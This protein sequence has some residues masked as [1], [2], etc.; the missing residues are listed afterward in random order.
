M[1]KKKTPSRVSA[2][3]Q[4]ALKKRM[5]I[6]YAT[7]TFVVLA[8]ILL[9]V[10]FYKGGQKDLS[11]EGYEK[12]IARQLGL[13]FDKEGELAFLSENGDTLAAI[14]IEIA[15]DNAERRIGLMFR[16]SMKENQGMLFIFPDEA[17]RSFWMR[18]TYMS[19]DMIFVNRNDEIVTIQ[20][21]TVPLTENSYFSTRPAVYVIEV[22]AGFA[23]RHGIKVGGRISW[24][25]N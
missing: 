1:T 3:S 22:N 16:E 18:N 15:D 11:D 10:L 25:R 4:N 23:D 2:A 8:G 14:D 24:K 13:N 9:V 12:D 20:K 21:N 6:T 19:L 5:L 7:I 17:I